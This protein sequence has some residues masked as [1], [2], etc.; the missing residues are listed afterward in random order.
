MLEAENENRMSL[1]HYSV[2]GK[3]IVYILVLTTEERIYETFAN[4][5]SSSKDVSNSI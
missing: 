4:F 5:Q 2:E 1:F 3:K